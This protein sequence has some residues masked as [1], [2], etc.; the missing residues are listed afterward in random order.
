MYRTGRV[1]RTRYN[2]WK[3]HGDNFKLQLKS[4]NKKVVVRAF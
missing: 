2:I 3:K 4:F 1:K